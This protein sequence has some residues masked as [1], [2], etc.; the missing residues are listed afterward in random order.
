MGGDHFGETVAIDEDYIIIGSH[1]KDGDSQGLNGDQDTNVAPNSGAVYIYEKIEDTW[2]L[3]TYLK[4]SDNKLAGEFGFRLNLHDD[5][6]AVS[7]IQKRDDSESELSGGVYLF[8]KQA[9]WDEIAFIEPD[10]PLDRFGGCLASSGNYL[11]VGASFDNAKAA[12]VNPVNVTSGE[13]GHFGSAFLF[14]LQNGVYQQVAYLKPSNPQV[15]GH[16]G[17]RC[18]V[19]DD[20]IVVGAS[21]DSTA[22]T[23]LNPNQ[24][25]FEE[26]EKSGAVY[27]FPTE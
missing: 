2:T 24:S 16:F 1:L 22:G 27:I 5:I 13:T 17:S 14:E 15:E 10:V 19:A 26:A 3:Q 23:G 11:L 20:F 4:A 25:I 12:G 6:L 7:A 8:S 21:F 9:G 18:G